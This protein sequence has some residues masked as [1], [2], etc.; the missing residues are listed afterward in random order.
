MESIVVLCNRLEAGLKRHKGA[1]PSRAALGEIFEAYQKERIPRMKR[2]LD[3]SSL[4]TR[5]QAWD[6]AL[7]KI[8]ANWIV[9]YAPD[10]LVA[11][12]LGKIIREAPK[13]SYVPV[14]VSFRKGSV[15]WADE[16]EAEVPAT[17][18]RQESTA[19]AAGIQAPQKFVPKL[20]TTSAPVIGTLKAEHLDVLLKLTTA[21]LG[22][23]TMLYLLIKA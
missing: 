5:L 2:I 23:L 22:V 10:R 3:Y 16:M 6:N 8:A 4:I 17:S 7:F 15:I 13:L 21:M 11:D 20:A 12:D 19:A 9:P 14:P 18:T 1:K